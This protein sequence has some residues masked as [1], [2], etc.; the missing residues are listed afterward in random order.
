MELD[1]LF[2]D[3]ILLE[4]ENYRKMS[5]NVYDDYDEASMRKRLIEEHPDESFIIYCYRGNLLISFLRFLCLDN[6]I[7]IISFQIREGYEY[8]LR[9]VM[10]KTYFKFKDL[11][12]EFVQSEVYKDNQLSLALHTKL[13]FHYL[14]DLD[15]KL[16]F[17][18]PKQDFL[19]S[20]ERYVRPKLLT[21]ERHNNSGAAD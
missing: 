17:L 5:R 12:F 6:R 14:E 8:C 4:Q 10:E 21:K 2:Q 11:D 20:L 19:A 13:E 3:M 16:R 7:R 9:N 15:N 1:H 18:T